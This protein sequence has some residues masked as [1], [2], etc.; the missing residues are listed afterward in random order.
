MT[1]SLDLTPAGLGS[2]R[3]CDSESLLMRNRFGPQATGDEYG[4]AFVLIGDKNDLAIK[5]LFGPRATGDEYGGVFVS[6]KVRLAGLQDV[7]Y[8]EPGQA[9]PSPNKANDES[10]QSRAAAIARNVSAVVIERPTVP[11]LTGDLLEDARLATGLTLDQIARA[12][13]VSARAVATWRAD[14]VPRHREVFFQALRSIGLSLVGG[15]GQS[16]VQ[17]WFLAGAPTRLDR[18]AAGEID[19]VAKEA[20]AYETSPAT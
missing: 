19:D 6:A 15:L 1:V 20:R 9:A 12:T 14:K 17:R 4:G 7:V 16:G 5:S 18:L 13:A 10:L 2:L 8:I 3:S 11:Q